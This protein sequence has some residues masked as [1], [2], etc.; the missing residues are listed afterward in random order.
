MRNLKR[1][2]NLLFFCARFARRFGY[3]TTLR[4]STHG[5]DKFTMEYSSHQQVNQ[6]QMEVLIKENKIEREKEQK[7]QG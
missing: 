7:K 6:D 2:P 4:S 5:K 3:S 1:A